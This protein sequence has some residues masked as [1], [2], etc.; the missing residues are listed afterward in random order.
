MHSNHHNCIG[1]LLQVCILVYHTG[2]LSPCASNSLANFELSQIQL[3]S[4]FCFVEAFVLQEVGNWTRMVSFLHFALMLSFYCAP[5]IVCRTISW[6]SWNKYRH[7]EVSVCFL[8]CALKH[9]LFVNSA[10]YGRLHQ[11]M[12][13]LL[14]TSA[15][16]STESFH[17][18]KECENTRREAELPS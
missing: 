15:Y 12:S 10:P 18:I 4:M 1:P 6:Y 9:I 3:Q 8:W 2:I 13:H 16:P 7:I 5:Y 11:H 17:M 14:H